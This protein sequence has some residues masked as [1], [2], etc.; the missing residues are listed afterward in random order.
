MEQAFA[1]EHRQSL[2]ATA[3]ATGK[4]AGQDHA[5]RLFAILHRPLLP[6][7]PRARKAAVEPVAI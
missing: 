6:A 7:C 3:H 4:A 1:A 5:Q 2:V